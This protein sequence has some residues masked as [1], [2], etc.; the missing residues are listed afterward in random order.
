MDLGAFIGKKL[1]TAKNELEKLGFS[2]VVKTNVNKTKEN[3][4][5]LVVRAKLLNKKEV[6]LVVGDFTFLS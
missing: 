5:S 4:I 1:Q 3:S 6:E 2:V